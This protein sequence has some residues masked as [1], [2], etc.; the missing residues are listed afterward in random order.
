[1]KLNA[2]LDDITKN[3]ISVKVVASVYVVEFQ[4]RGPH[5]HILII[6]NDHRKPRNSSDYGKFVSAEIPDTEL[7][8]QHHVTVTTCMIHAP[9]GRGINSPYTREDGMAIVILFK[10]VVGLDSWTHRVKK[11]RTALLQLEWGRVSFITSMQTDHDNAS[12]P[13]ELITDGL[14]YTILIFAKSMIVACT[15]KCVQAFNQ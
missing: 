15:W 4:N 6:L 9:C 11:V 3:G 14:F 10:D 7:F 12:N 5:A 2:L 1:M 13:F 8:P